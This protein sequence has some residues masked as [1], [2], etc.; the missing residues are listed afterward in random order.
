MYKMQN[1]INNLSLTLD[2]CF[3]IIEYSHHTINMSHL[4]I[5]KMLHTIEYH[6]IIINIHWN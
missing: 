6:I 1:T 3:H 4:K 2:K 5:D